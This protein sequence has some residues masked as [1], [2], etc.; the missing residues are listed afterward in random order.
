MDKPLEQ[1]VKA[2]TP[3]PRKVYEKPSFR[4]EKV[5][6]IQTLS[7]GKTGILPLLF[8]LNLKNS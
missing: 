2:D 5:F 4:Y 8:T 7:C 6:E 1:S 3:T